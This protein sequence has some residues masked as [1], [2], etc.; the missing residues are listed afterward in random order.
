MN[1]GC[2]SCG[3]NFR[4]KNV[5]KDIDKNVIHF[6]YHS[7]MLCKTTNGTDQEEGI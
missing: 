1:N 5:N 4:E 7:A 3:T 2:M 6:T